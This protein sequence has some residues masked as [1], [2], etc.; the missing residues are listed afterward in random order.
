MNIGIKAHW[1]KL[2]G[3]KFW[4]YFAPGAKLRAPKWVLSVLKKIY[5]IIILLLILLLFSKKIQATVKESLWRSLEEDLIPSLSTMRTNWLDSQSKNI[6]EKHKQ[7]HICV[8]GGTKFILFCLSQ[9]G[10]Y[11]MSMKLHN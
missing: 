4:A 5:K 2:N 3:K 8:T 11:D 1:T 9:R 10:F 7:S 6:S